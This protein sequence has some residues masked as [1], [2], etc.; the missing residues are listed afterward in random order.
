MSAFSRFISAIEYSK[1]VKMTGM[2]TPQNTQ[3]D[4]W[5]DDPFADEPKPSFRAYKQSDSAKSAVENLPTRRAPQSTNSA[6]ASRLVQATPAENLDE[7]AD[8]DELVQELL[9]PDKQQFVIRDAS[10]ASWVVRKIVEARARQQR[11]KDWAQ[12]EL[13]SAQREEKF[14]LERFGDELEAWTAENNNGKKTLRLPDGTLG[15]RH[16]RAVIQIQDEDRVLDWCRDHLPEAVKVSESVLKTPLN[17]HLKETGEL[18]PGCDLDNGGDEF[19][20][21]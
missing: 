4:R 11:I 13:Q 15:F 7:T 5:D 21:K 8:E 9:P 3:D 20:V 1:F 10:D 19:Y 17:E 14:F 16:K 6:S 18:P 2:N 12:A